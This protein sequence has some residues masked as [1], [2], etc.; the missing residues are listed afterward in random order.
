MVNALVLKKGS[1]MPDKAILPF[2][3]RMWDAIKY[4]EVGNGPSY[5]RTK[6]RPPGGSTA[7]G[8]VQLTGTTA[9]DYVDRGLVSP[10]AATFYNT[11]MAPIY[12]NFAMY[13]NEPNKQ[14]YDKT[15]DYG[16]NAG[17]FADNLDMDANIPDMDGYDT[18][19]TDI[20]SSMWKQAGGDPE[21]FITIWRGVNRQADPRYFN[22]V[23][24]RF[25]EPTQ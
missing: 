15:W 20:M 3:D 14:G 13:G 17:G 8:P 9:K 19:S 16:G 21:R 5:I 10:E 7:F 22:T 4:A 18:L 11:R 2:P 1:N 23:M 12:K 25:N 24:S 6:S